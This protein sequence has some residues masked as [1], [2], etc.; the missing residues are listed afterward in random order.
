M[1]K[2]S[3]QRLLSK[4]AIIAATASP[5]LAA[6]PA[7]QAGPDPQLICDGTIDAEHV[8]RRD[9]A[10]LLGRNLAIALERMRP[11]EATYVATS[12]A[13]S[14]DPLRKL[15]IA[16]ALEWAFPLVGDAVVIEHLSRDADSSI[17]AACARAAWIRRATGG[18]LGVLD[19]LAGDP[20]EDV[21]AI[22]AWP[23]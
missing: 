7:E 20:D 10:A 17:R 16:R 13:I 22:A 11:I 3:L 14:P 21:R 12:W 15:G 5:A 2:I 23:R 1:L 8:D 18:D 4:L 19:R 9:A 6:S